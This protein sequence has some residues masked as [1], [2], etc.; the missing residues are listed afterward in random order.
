MLGFIVIVSPIS[1]PYIMAHPSKQQDIVEAAYRLFKENGFYATGV[2]LIMREAGVSKRTLY[3]YFSSKND[4]IVAVLTHYHSTYQD[5]LEQLLNQSNATAVDKIA[6]IFD[7][8]ALWFDEASFHGCLA[9]NAMGEFYGK[10]EK[11]EQACHQFKRW[12]LTLLEQ[13]CQQANT[14]SPKALAYKL[15]AL[16]EGMVS[17]ALIDNE[18]APVNLTDVA[19]QIIASHQ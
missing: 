19:K 17:L 5:R 1:T 3:K 8:A 11:I 13:L 10:D 6:L 16:L 4:L 9:I 14:P 2:D 15:F 18:H 12:E 7:D